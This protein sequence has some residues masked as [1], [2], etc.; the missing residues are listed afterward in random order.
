M[1]EKGKDC[2]N[3]GEPTKVQLQQF[4]RHWRQIG[5]AQCRNCGWIESP[6]EK[7][8]EVE[9]DFSMLKSHEKRYIKDRNESKFIIHML[10]AP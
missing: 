9:V 8:V 5:P 10:T 4:G 2:P 7:E 1:F 3:C 6:R